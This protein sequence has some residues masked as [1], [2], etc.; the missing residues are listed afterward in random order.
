MRCLA[1][2][3]YLGV[4]REGSSYPFDI[5]VAITMGRLMIG[6]SMPPTL[7]EVRDL[8]CIVDTKTLTRIGPA[9]GTGRILS[10]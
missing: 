2:F 6:P 1:H 5:I 3:L 9:V 10:K 4:F 8:A 7:L